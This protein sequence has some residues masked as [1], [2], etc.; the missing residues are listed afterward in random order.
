MYSRSLGDLVHS[1]KTGTSTDRKLD[2]YAKFY[3]Y[4]G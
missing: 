4:V 3:Y 2:C 1:L